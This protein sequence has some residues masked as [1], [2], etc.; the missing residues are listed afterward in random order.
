MRKLIASATTVA[1]LISGAATASALGSSELSSGNSNPK[2]VVKPTTTPVAP[3]TPKT[4]TAKPTPTPTPEPTTTTEPAPTFTREQLNAIRDARDYNNMYNWSLKRLYDQLTSPYG[5]GFSRDD[6]ILAIAVVNPD[7]KANALAAAI[8]YQN[9]MG[10]S[11][12]RIYEQLVSPYGG[13]FTEE[14]AQYAMDNLPL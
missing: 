6:A 7:F 11:R 3:T 10:M 14:Q 2:P 13:S 4:T 8:D 5:G 9:L 1:M 12:S